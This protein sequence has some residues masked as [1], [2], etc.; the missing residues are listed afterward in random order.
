MQFIGMTRNKRKH[1]G[2]VNEHAKEIVQRAAKEDLKLKVQWENSKVDES[3]WKSP[4]SPFIGGS[5][6]ARKAA[7]MKQNNDAQHH[8]KSW[9]RKSMKD[10]VNE[11][12]RPIP[13]SIKPRVDRY[14]ACLLMSNI[15]DIL[16]FHSSPVNIRKILVAE[17]CSRAGC[18]IPVKLPSTFKNA[19]EYYNSLTGQILLES[20][21]ILS[22]EMNKMKRKIERE[23]MDQLCANELPDTLSLDLLDHEVIEQGNSQNLHYRLVLKFQ[24]QQLPKNKEHFEYLRPGTCFQLMPSFAKRKTDELFPVI[25]STRPALDRVLDMIE[26]TVYDLKV[27]KYLVDFVDIREWVALPLVSLINESRQFEVCQKQPNVL[28]MD[29]IIGMKKAKH[30][31]F[32]QDSDEEQGEENNLGQCN[33]SHLN[34]CEGTKFHNLQP[35]KIITPSG[36][37]L[38]QLNNSQCKLICDFL[39]PIKSS[40]L[41]LVQVR[42]YEIFL[43]LAFCIGKIIY[44]FSLIYC[45]KGATW[46]GKDNLSCFA[47]IP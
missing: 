16:A 14:F 36:P 46:N 27:I 38:P 34:K 6:A 26:L 8:T 28:F 40:P 13:K 23:E 10:D 29:K 15:K 12:V 44:F 20:I 35:F 4:D 11:K 18:L 39:G 33:D 22:S 7:R 32:A 45:L 37:R 47:F 9:R 24:M 31:R 2:L 25:A 17:A 43:M 1:V 42:A 3:V 19:N 5:R 21:S 30:I 41:S